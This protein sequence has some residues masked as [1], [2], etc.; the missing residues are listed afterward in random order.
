M[1]TIPAFAI[2]DHKVTQV[3]AT[4]HPECYVVTDEHGR[5]WIR[6]FG[7]VYRDRVASEPLTIFDFAHQGA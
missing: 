6:N 4:V 7:A 1:D 5:T 2:I 3:R